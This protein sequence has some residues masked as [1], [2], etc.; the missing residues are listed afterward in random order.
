M[1]DPQKLIDDIH[2]FLGRSDQTL[3]DDVRMLVGELNEL[4]VVAAGSGG[5]GGG[6][7]TFGGGI[8]PR[9]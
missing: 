7:G 5:T 6:G 3:T 2:G 8:L 9:T 1:R 4:C